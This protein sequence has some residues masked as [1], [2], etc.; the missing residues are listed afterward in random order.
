MK[1]VTRVGVAGLVTASAAA[2]IA[3]AAAADRAAA[4]ERAA[5]QVSLRAASTELV[6]GHKLVLSGKVKPAVAGRKVVL[7]KKIGQRKW[8][9]EKRL[10]TNK[11]GRFSYVDRPS[12]PGERL[13]RVVVPRSGT[14]K[15]G[16]SEVVRVTIYQWLDLS[17]LPARASQ[18]TV[19]NG[20]S[21]GGTPFT[22]SILS[23]AGAGQ[24]FMDWNLDP[25]CTTLRTRFGAGD[26]SDAD[27]TAHVTL[28]GDGEQLYAGQFTLTK[29]EGREFD[30]S[31]VF[32][33]A[34]TWSSTKPSSP[35]PQPGA[36]AVM[37]E[38]MVLCAI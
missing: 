35:E 12:T 16:V 13:Y 32:R 6:A 7:Q 1:L 9:T 3:P 31:G 4:N 37:A 17:V 34:F 30:V 25:S 10:T 11:R 38:P 19:V 29:S 15:A 5:H 28:T 36:V 18:G 26:N 21:I 27:A 23:M 8:A 22:Q 20:V 33:L 14:V 24:G 2:L